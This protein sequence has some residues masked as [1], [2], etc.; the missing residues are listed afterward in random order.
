MATFARHGLGMGELPAADEAAPAPA[1]RRFE[2]GDHSAV[3][4]VDAEETGGAY[5][6]LDVDAQPGGGTPPHTH[7]REEETFFVLE[8]RFAILIGG[9][10]VEAGPGDCVYA[11]RDV[12]HAWRNAGDT[13]A[14]M[15][16]LVTPGGIE[17]FFAEVEQITAQVAGALDAAVFE[18]IAA[19]AARYG[20]EIADP[21][22]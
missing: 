7:T 11:P 6:L 4:L 21:I 13:P 20:L 3:L 22:K 1:R 17:R 12:V 5:A 15:L 16:V 10:T 8:G 2:L 19:L 18:K 9:Q 14:R